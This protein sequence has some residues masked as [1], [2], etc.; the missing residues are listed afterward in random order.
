MSVKLYQTLAVNSE[1]VLYVCKTIPDSRC[2]HFSLSSCRHVCD[3]FFCVTLSLFNCLV[4]VDVG[5]D[6]YIYIYIY[7]VTDVGIDIDIYIVTDVGIDIDIY[8]YSD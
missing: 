7:I 4:N 3:W 5:I 1:R 8:I 2:V 6:I